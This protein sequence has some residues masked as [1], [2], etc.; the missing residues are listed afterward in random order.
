MSPLAIIKLVN[1]FM[2]FV[3]MAMGMF[4]DEGLRKDGENRVIAGN[5]VRLIKA[6]EK[7]HAKVQSFDSAIAAARS[8]LPKRHSGN[9]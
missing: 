6:R 8:K 2:S 5:A 9:K 3:N 7:A 1:G 4:R